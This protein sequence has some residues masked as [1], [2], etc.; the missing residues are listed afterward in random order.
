VPIDFSKQSRKAL[1]YA[2]PLA[3]K[4]GAGITLLYYLVR[5]HDLAAADAHVVLDQVAEEER[6]DP[7]LV[8]NTLVSTGIAASQ[9]IVRTARDLQSDLI[10]ISTHLY[11]GVMHRLFGSSTTD[12]VARHAPCP[13]LIV[14]KGGRDF[15]FG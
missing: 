3:A 2:C 10:I 4:F 5:G 15:A 6:I 8:R 7:E 12:L 14:P 9:A 1:R 13:V 11:A